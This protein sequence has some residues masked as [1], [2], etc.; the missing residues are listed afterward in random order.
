MLQSLVEKSLVRFGSERYALLETIGE[1]ALG[2]REQ[3]G[4]LEDTRR[5]H[6]DFF[7]AFA[8]AADTSA[9]GDYGQR[10]ELLLREQENLR[11]AVDGAAGTGDRVGAIELMILLEN[12]WVTTDPFEGA[13]RFE[14]LLATGEELPER[15]RARALRCYAGSLWLAGRYELSHHKNEESLAL[16]RALGDDEGVAVL[17]HRIGISTLGHLQDTKKARE[18]LNESLEYFR[19]AGS[20]RGES[21][22]IGG[23]GY[24]ARE[25]GDYE[26]AVELFSRA[27]ELSVE[28]GFTWWEVGMLAALANVLLELGR[29][30]EAEAA[31]RRARQLAHA[32]RDRHASG[33][34]LVPLGWVPAPRRGP[35]PA[36]PVLG[37]GEGR[38]RPGPNRP[39]EG[40]RG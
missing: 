17:L 31:A 9:E 14:E 34:G 28:T 24:V 39:T 32:I 1:L 2:R 10:P 38:E 4:E 7:L 12:F 22:A 18:L 40:L 25:E 30:D 20:S 15:L 23:L 33:G 27:A 19:R 13:R 8:K 6:Y 29:L 16:F 3:A 26:E 37:G 21:E 5:R 35:Q 11:A 36:R